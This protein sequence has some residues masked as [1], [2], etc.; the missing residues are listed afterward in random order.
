M[1]TIINKIKAFILQK[2]V[3]PIIPIINKIKTFI[4]QFMP[5]IEPIAGMMIIVM[6]GFII[7]KITLP[8]ISIDGLG[9]YIGGY[10][11]GAATLMAVLKTLKITD[12]IQKE[13]LIENEKNR[14]LSLKY[15]REE[16][17]HKI[18]EYIAK[19]INEINVFYYNK[20]IMK[21]LQKIKD[22]RIKALD[23]LNN[24]IFNYE[25]DPLTYEYIDIT[26]NKIYKEHVSFELNLI[27]KDLNEHTPNRK[28]A[29]EYYFLLNI[30][31][32]NISIADSLLL[33][34]QKIHNDIFDY[35]GNDPNFVEKH[36]AELRD[37]TTKFINEYIEYKS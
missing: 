5:I 9:S 15:K 37:L 3:H 17:A 7:K 20:L 29:N 27:E 13:N 10:V 19:Y 30:L 28:I 8:N 23:V 21:D 6:A 35:N 14:Q 31:L 1:L 4:L 26:K 32:K 24:N 34:L 22:N 36:T 18:A 12:K 16:F 33:K 11:G 25:K 2:L